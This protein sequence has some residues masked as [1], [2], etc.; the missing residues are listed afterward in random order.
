MSLPSTFTRFQTD[1]FGE[2]SH[3]LCTA[4]GHHK[5]ELLSSDIAFA[6]TMDIFQKSNISVINLTGRS[7]VRL[8]RFQAL[9]QIVLWLPRMGWVAETL[10]GKPLVAE[11]GSAMLCL[12]GD[13]LLGETTP[14][15]HGISIIMPISLFG[16]PFPGNNC[17]SRH[18]YNTADA[19][20][21]VE[22]ALELGLAMKQCITSIDFLLAALIDQL[23]FWLHHSDPQA[24]SFNSA[25]SE[26]RRLLSLARDWI[27]SH[28]DQPF[29]MADLAAALH[30]SSRSLQYCFCEELGHSPLVETRRIRFRKL[31]QQLLLTPAG[32][33]R[34]ELIFQRC[35]LPY[36]PVIRRHYLNWCGETPKQTQAR[37]TTFASTNPLQLKRDPF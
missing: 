37:A 30:V 27:D 29:R 31:R 25:S 35:G 3:R 8:H 14:Y 5:S 32:Q 7:S 10:N 33:E 16:E 34:I 20:N 21:V 4:I 26:H 17:S 22:T 28:L 13:E 15:L 23:S 19:V 24:T 11:S 6:A 2:W 12:P 18:V 1:N 9:D 36:S